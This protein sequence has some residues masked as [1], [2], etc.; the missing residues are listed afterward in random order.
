ME[1]QKKILE[2]AVKLFSSHGYAET[3]LAQVARAA[4]VSKALVLWYFESKEQLFRAALQHFL[5]P[6]EIDARALD[7]LDEYQQIE[8]LIDDYYDFIAEHLYSVRFVLGQVVGGDENS[9]ELAA[10]A[11]ELHVIYRGLLTSILE[12]GR[13]NGLFAETVRPTEDAALIMAT[14]NGLLLHQLV[15]ALDATKARELLARLKCSV[16]AQ[17]ERKTPALAVSAAEADAL[18]TRALL[19]AGS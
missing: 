17:L 5:A 6:Y 15:E 3:S 1:S 14:L 10:R 11:R 19:R 13:G 8:K 2:T 4:R 18:T 7:G 16:R 12:R 9:Q